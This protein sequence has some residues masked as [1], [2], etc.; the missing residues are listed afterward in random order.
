M[1]ASV[2]NVEVIQ[3]I[4]HIIP[5]IHHLHQSFVSSYSS[6]FFLPLSSPSLPDRL[7]NQLPRPAEDR[8]PSGSHSGRSLSS[9][10]PPLHLISSSFF[11]SYLFLL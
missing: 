9:E 10:S 11:L 4:D 2:S 6:L 3:S 7:S 1:K 8:L 5:S